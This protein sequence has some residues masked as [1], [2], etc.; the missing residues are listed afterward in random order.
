M[1]PPAGSPEWL[2]WVTL[3]LLLLRPP[4]YLERG[5]AR[6]TEREEQ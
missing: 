1:G 5:G 2:N 6:L 3:R 4:R